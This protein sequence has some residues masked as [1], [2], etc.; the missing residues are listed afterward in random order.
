[1]DP[2]HGGTGGNLVEQ[3]LAATRHWLASVDAGAFT[4]Q[5]METEHEPQLLLELNVLSKF[6]EINKVFLYRTEASRKVSL[7]VLYGSF[8]DRAAAQDAL[9]KLPLSLKAN[10]PFLRTVRGVRNDVGQPRSPHAFGASAGQPFG[11]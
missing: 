9:D 5:L 11:G 6:I 3:R 8:S 7:S 4:I 2:R 10:R 1:M